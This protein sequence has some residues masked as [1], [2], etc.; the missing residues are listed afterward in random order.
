MR[1]EHNAIPAD[2]TKKYIYGYIGPKNVL[3]IRTVFTTDLNTHD[4]HFKGA[5]LDIGTQRSVIDYYQA[6]AYAL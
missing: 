5:H 6:G 1:L 2:C 4:S 3:D